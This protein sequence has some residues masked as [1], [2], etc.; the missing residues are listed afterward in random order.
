MAHQAEDSRIGNTR[1]KV[2]NNGRNNS[3]VNSN[4]LVICVELMTGPS[5]EAVEQEWLRE[6]G[7]K[8]G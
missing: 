4:P 2:E 1:W 8:A 3:E 5:A 7:S 6:I